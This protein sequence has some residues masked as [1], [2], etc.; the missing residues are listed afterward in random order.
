MQNSNRPV[1]YSLASGCGWAIVGLAIAWRLSAVGSTLYE[2]I[3]EF[4]G[5]LVAAPMIGLFVGWLFRAFSNTGRPAQIGIA[6]V[7]LLLAAWLFLAGVGVAKLISEGASWSRW[8]SVLVSEPLV[9]TFWG[10]IYT[11][12]ALLLWPL[13]YMNHVF[14]SRMWNRRAELESALVGNATSL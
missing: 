8:I 6:L 2:V 14:I 4:S 12:Y 1:V 7:A 11:G 3:S 9:G 13:S 10:L 5:G